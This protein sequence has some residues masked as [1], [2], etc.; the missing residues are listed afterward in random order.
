MLCH[1]TVDTQPYYRYSW[2]LTV[3][4]SCCYSVYSCYYYSCSYCGYCRHS[5]LYHSI[6]SYTLVLLACTPTTTLCIPAATT[7]CIPTATTLCIP[8]AT[9]PILL[10]S[11]HVHI[12]TI[13]VLSYTHQLR[14]SCVCFLFIFLSV[15]S[16]LILV[17]SLTLVYSQCNL[18]IDSYLSTVY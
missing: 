4:Y 13:V 7:L 10:Y 5:I 11:Q 9:T 8:T 14:V 3:T 2:L 6:Y 12:D 17:K 15:H 18:Y 1:D 16:Y